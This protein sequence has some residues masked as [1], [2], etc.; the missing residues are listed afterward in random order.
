MKALACYRDGV[1]GRY[2]L[3]VK[4]QEATQ[5]QV[6]AAVKR[7]FV[8]NYAQGIVVEEIYP[9]TEEDQGIID[10]IRNKKE[11]PS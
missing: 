6:T 5:E 11:T 2:R 7:H 4:V 10:A 1:G 8:E 3:T 9:V